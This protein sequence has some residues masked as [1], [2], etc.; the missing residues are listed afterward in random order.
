MNLAYESTHADVPS[1][2]S[3]RGLGVHFRLLGPPVPHRQAEK[4]P[5]LGSRLDSFSGFCLPCCCLKSHRCRWFLVGF[6]YFYLCNNLVVHEILCGCTF[7]YLIWFLCADGVVPCAKMNRV[8]RGRFHSALLAR[9]EVNSCV[10][11]S[12]SLLLKQSTKCDHASICRRLKRKR[13]GGN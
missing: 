6:N 2:D 10:S 3:H 5:L 8:R 7:L 11:F 4:A 1:E 13:C 12:T 9:D